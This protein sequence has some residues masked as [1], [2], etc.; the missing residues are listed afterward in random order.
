MTNIDQ[1]DRFGLLLAKARATTNLSQASVAKKLGVSKN[2]IQN[3]ESGMSNPDMH[4]SIEFFKAI[5]VNPVPYL[6]EYLYPNSSEG[7]NL[8]AEAYQIVGDMSE[9]ELSCFIYLM[10]GKHGSSPYAVLQEVVANLRC[11]LGDRQSIATLI[12]NNFINALRRNTL[13]GGPTPDMDIFRAALEAGRE[14][15]V[16]N[17]NEY[18][19]K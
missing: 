4:E 6:K 9:Q 3:W 10:T 12:D 11:P 16:N 19:C 17:Y 8:R 1:R 2:T 13:V 14:A 7:C 15:Y 18:I 5:N